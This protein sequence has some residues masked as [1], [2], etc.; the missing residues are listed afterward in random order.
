MRFRKTLVR[1]VKNN[2]AD[3]KHL[4]KMKPSSTDVHNKDMKIY[5]GS[6]A[7]AGQ[8]MRNNLIYNNIT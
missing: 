2:T 7:H 8:A 6:P 4:E 5:E 3:N 1:S